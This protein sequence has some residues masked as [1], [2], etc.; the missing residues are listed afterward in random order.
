[1]RENIITKISFRP[2][3]DPRTG[4]RAMPEI[5]GGLPKDPEV[6]KFIYVR[7]AGIASAVLVFLVA[8]Y[9]LRSVILGVEVYIVCA[10]VVYGTRIVLG[11]FMTKSR[12][13]KVLY[14]MTFSSGFG[15]YAI[16][17]IILVAAILR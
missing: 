6:E 17:A 8:D 14:F 7:I 16:L 1:M 4:T 3:L 12:S 10:F 2:G 11:F 15:I 9:L 13:R 5:P